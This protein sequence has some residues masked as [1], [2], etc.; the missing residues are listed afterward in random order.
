MNM[1]AVETASAWSCRRGFARDSAPN[2]RAPVQVVTEAKD[3]VYCGHAGQRPAS[4]SARVDSHAALPRRRQ[5]RWRLFWRVAAGPGSMVQ[6]WRPRA[7]GV[8]GFVWG[9]GETAANGAPLSGFGGRRGRRDSLKSGPLPGTAPQQSFSIVSASVSLCLPHLDTPTPLP[10]P[11]RGSGF[12]LGQAR[13]A[14]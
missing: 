14:C 11:T 5:C 6:K 7:H 10:A 13:K 4:R 9:E 12:A 3:R 8:P 2:E 1:Q